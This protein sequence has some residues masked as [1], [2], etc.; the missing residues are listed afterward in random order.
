[1]RAGAGRQEEGAGELQAEDRG[2]EK[3]PRQE[4]RGL[5]GGPVQ[6]QQDK[7]YLLVACKIKRLLLFIPP[8][9]I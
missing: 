5:R 6:V 8:Y 9:I 7:G 2:D 1:M 4:D 3:H